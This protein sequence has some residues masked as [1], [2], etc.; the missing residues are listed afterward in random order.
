M[1]RK[2]RIGARERLIFRNSNVARAAHWSRPRNAS[3]Y[4]PQR[5]RGRALKQVGV[6]PGTDVAT[7]PSMPV[8]QE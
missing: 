6:R 5:H 4:P 3:R 1:T 7:I 2:T 8:I